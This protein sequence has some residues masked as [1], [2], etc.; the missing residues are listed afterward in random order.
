MIGGPA[1][2]LLS[3]SHP[4]KNHRRFGLVT[5]AIRWRSQLGTARIA[6][7]VGVRRLLATLRTSERRVPP[8]HRFEQTEHRRD[9][10]G[11][12]KDQCQANHGYDDQFDET[13]AHH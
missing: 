11:Q 7:P 5:V 6:P 8:L 12:A 10:L 3:L 9:S 13:D 1:L 2:R 4:T